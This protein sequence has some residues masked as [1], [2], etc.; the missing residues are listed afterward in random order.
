V[1]TELTTQMAK[2][3]REDSLAIIAATLKDDPLPAFDR[4]KG[5]RLLM[6]AQRPDADGGGTGLE[7]ARKDAKQ[8]SFEGTSHWPHL[9]KP[10]EFNRELEEFLQE[11]RE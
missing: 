4:Y 7:R 8:V 2:M 1:R 9:D 10:R 6:Y 11:I 5:P 3:P